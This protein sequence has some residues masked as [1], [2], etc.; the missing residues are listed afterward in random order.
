MSRYVVA[1]DSMKGCLSSLEASSAFAIGIRKTDP[2]AEVLVVPV[3]DGGE[4]TAKVL[5]HGAGLKESLKN[6]VIGPMGNEVDAE[7]WYDR[8]TSTAYIDMAQTSGLTL[9]DVGN[10]NPLLATSY[11]F[12]QLISKALDIGATT[13][14]AGLGGS[15]TVDGGVGACQALGIRF[16]DSNGSL[17]PDFA[18]GRHL[19]VISNI[20]I[21]GIDARLNDVHLKLVCDVDNPFTGLKGAAH[22]FGPQK[23]ASEGDITILESGLENLRRVIRSIC[24]IDL[25][26]VA[27]SGA[28]GGCAGG[29]KALAG[30]VICNGAPFVLDSLKFESMIREATTIITGEGSSDA[31]TLM[32]KL[33]YGILRLGKATG[34]SVALVAGNIKD[35]AKLKEAGFSTLYNINNPEIIELS[36]TKSM[37]AMMPNVAK[38]RLMATGAKFALYAKKH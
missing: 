33:P 13:I 34:V 16:I 32:G 38:C 5:A 8:N 11:G 7:W 25:N 19:S 9:V 24:G 35:S 1:I 3:A 23:G 22:V 30:G 15:A 37:P 12:G 18:G 10:R 28:A 2:E 27:G 29:L 4:G 21:T 26:E 14:V 17:I 31:Q 20:D 36:A 6:S